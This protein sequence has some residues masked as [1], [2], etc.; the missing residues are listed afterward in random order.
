MRGFNIW[1]PIVLIVSALATNMLVMNLCILF[2]MQPGPAEN[3][4]FIAMMIV[5]LVIYTRF[6]KQRRRR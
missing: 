5:A 4:G 1:R 3:V 2:G 6:T